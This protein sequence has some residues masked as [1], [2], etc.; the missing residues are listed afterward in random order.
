MNLNRKFIGR[1]PNWVSHTSTVH[2]TVEVPVLIFGRQKG[3]AI[4][5][6]RLGALPQ[7]PTAFEKAGETFN[8][9]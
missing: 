3:F 6:W 8:H 4:C 9:R 7:D 2:R 1:P 5:E